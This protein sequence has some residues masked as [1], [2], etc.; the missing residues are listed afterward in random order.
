MGGIGAKGYG[1]IP[2]T[3]GKV[4]PLVKDA[5]D[6]NHIALLAIDNKVGTDIEL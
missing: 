6:I 2:K 4:H 3:G 5:D 1:L